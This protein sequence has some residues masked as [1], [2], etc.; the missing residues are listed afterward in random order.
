MGAGALFQLR[1]HHV[2]NFDIQAKR[3][4]GTR[5][6]ASVNGIARPAIGS[7]VEVSHRHA[8]AEVEAI[9]QVGSD[10]VWQTFADDGGGC[11]WFSIF[12]SE[13]A[14]IRDRSR[15]FVAR[16]LP[17]RRVRSSKEAR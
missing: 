16:S 11:E 17:P 13:K 1:K 3:S 6:Q 4:A 7:G 15:S 9:T 10:N 14:K 12:G 2:A 5:I 8:D